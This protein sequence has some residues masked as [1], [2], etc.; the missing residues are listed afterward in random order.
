MTRKQKLLIFAISLSGVLMSL[1]ALI[2]SHL[3]GV[4][5]LENT[6]AV[7][8]L[9]AGIVAVNGYLMAAI[10]TAREEARRREEDP[11]R[12]APEK[13]YLLYGLIIA[14][15]LIQCLYVQYT[16]DEK[17]PYASI[18]VGVFL[19]VGV[20]IAGLWFML[21]KHEEIWE[22]VRLVEA[23][24]VPSFLRNNFV[25]RL[26]RQ[27][28]WGYHCKPAR[29]FFIGIGF[30]F[31]ILSGVYALWMNPVFVVERAQG[32]EAKW[33]YE[34]AR[35]Y[36]IGEGLPK[37]KD[38][39]FA[40][41]LAAARQGYG[42]AYFHAG[43]MYD[44]GLGTARNSAEAARWFRKAAE[45]GDSQAWNLLGL[46]YAKGEGLEQDPVEA[47]KCFRRAAEGGN[48]NGQYNL[49]LAYESGFGLAADEGLALYWYK[50]ADDDGYQDAR[51]KV[52]A[53]E[54]R[55]LRPKKPGKDGME[56]R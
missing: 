33:Q 14:A 13:Q 31:L 29:I 11:D 51:E 23:G 55:G 6:W 54:S 36:D 25:L 5:P 4:P 32:G 1:G 19:A 27:I 46:A 43:R 41:Y 37:D 12:A 45:T 21:S 52:K 26:M 3:K 50:Q 39:A 10:G 8:F 34:A 18:L 49:G 17:H 9:C 48:A 53:F 20:G 35:L 16:F 30:P 2:F 38:K 47:A 7:L 24:N 15:V 40:L 28:Y 42:K 44:L 22:A 56:E